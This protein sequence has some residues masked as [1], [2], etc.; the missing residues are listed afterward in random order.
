M[1]ALFLFV[2]TS[3]FIVICGLAA[4]SILQNPASA[5]NMLLSVVLTGLMTIRVWVTA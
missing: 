1:R 3:L 4:L 2:V 5:L